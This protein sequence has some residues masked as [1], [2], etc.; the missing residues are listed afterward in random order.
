MLSSPSLSP[1]P[2]HDWLAAMSPLLTER[3]ARPADLAHDLVAQGGSWNPRRN[4]LAV[5]SRT[6]ETARLDLTLACA[7]IHHARAVLVLE[8]CGAGRAVNGNLLWGL[9]EPGASARPGDGWTVSGS[10]ESCCRPPEHSVTYVVLDHAR[11]HVLTVAVNEPEQRTHV[12]VGAS[13]P[14]GRVPVELVEAP[15]H[16]RGPFTDAVLNQAAS[17]G[18]V[19]EVAAWYGA[20][21][22]LADAVVAG[23]RVASHDE[24]RLRTSVA[25]MD[26]LLSA[27]WA[28]IRDAVAVWERGPN[29][30][31]T[32]V[33]HV[34]RA[35]TLTRVAAVT[36]LFAYTS[37]EDAASCGAGPS[38]NLRE[39][40]ARWMGRADLDADS[41]V[42]AETV[43]A[44]GPSW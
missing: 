35:R 2:L 14:D 9:L 1:L 38:P 8:A 40:L 22:S 34:A 42:V 17:F 3:R 37:I 32:L 12:G 31:A 25:E 28:S 7:M 43:L 15:A 5:A 33:H 18:R 41:A 24:K 36:V 4:P 11:G 21:T 39:E 29:A 23:L 10:L 19:L 13:R 6:A 20:L 16:M 26:A 44:E 27:A 30:A